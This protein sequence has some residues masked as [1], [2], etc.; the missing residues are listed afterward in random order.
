MREPTPAPVRRRRLW[1]VFVPFGIVVVLAAGWTGLWFYAASAA[2]KA[3]AGWR[4]R[5]ASVGRV[6]ACGEQTI[7]GYPFR[8]EV[9]CADPSVEFRREVPPLA[10]KA[11]DLLVVAQIY[12]PTLLIAEFK[13]PTTIGEAGKPPG[14]TAEWTSGQASVRGTPFAPERVSVVFDGPALGR[15]GGAATAPLLK[16]KR[17]EL[18]GRMAE[19]SAAGNPVIDVALRLAAA[20][21]PELHPLTVAPLDAD[22]AATLR[23]LP[24]FAPK[25]WSQRLKELQAR[26]GKIEI[27]QARVQQGEVIAVSAGTLA[28]TERGGLDGQLQVTIVHLEQVLKALDV[29]RMVSE[30]ELGAKIDSLDRIIPGLGR[31]ARKNAAP[32]IVAGLGALGQNTTLEGKPA[33]TLPLRFADGQVLLGPIPIGRVPPLF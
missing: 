28:L 14:Y 18:H 29:E 24:D 10:L 7:G 27:T 30:G 11:A 2:E 23:G 8:I 9:R 22:I 20:T 1:P 21:A 12:Q 19:G 33:V 26:G 16:A 4:A 15:V 3:L 32:S 13:S 5:E 17:I 31:L 25:P 6:Y